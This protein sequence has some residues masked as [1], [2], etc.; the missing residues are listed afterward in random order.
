[1]S[2]QRIVP[3]AIFGSV[4]HG[5][6]TRR[7]RLGASVVLLPAVFAASAQAHTVTASATCNSVIPGRPSHGCVRLRNADITRLWPLVSVGT[8]IDVV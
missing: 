3:A 6:F 7:C 4:S 2:S 1:M 5:F 8:P